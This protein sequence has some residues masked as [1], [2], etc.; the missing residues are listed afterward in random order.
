[1]KFEFLILSFILFFLSMISFFK[2]EN[3]IM[4][5][6]SLELILNSVNIAIANLALIK[7]SI[8]PAFWIVMFFAVTACEVAIGLSIV[9]LIAKKLKIL[10]N[11]LLERI[12]DEE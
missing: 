10:E 1:M 7:S 3:L 8:T 4:M 12:K 11:S 5:L 6:L 2:S 9:I